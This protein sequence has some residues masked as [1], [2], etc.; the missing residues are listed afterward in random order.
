[1]ELEQAK[2]DYDEDMSTADARNAYVQSFFRILET[3]LNDHNWR[4]F[5]I[6]AQLCGFVQGSEDPFKGV[7]GSVEKAARKPTSPGPADG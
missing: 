1:M 5:L 6:S 2:R 4:V 3:R 7:S